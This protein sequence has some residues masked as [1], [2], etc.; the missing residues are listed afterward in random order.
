MLLYLLVADG[1]RFMTGLEKL[2]NQS[3]QRLLLAVPAFL[4][5]CFANVISAESFFF[6]NTNVS[7]GY[8]SSAVFVGSVISPTSNPEWKLVRLCLHGLLVQHLQ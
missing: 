8:S 5:L 4:M 6:F 3:G 7:A 1:F 2:T